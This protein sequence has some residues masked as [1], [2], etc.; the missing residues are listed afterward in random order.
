[1]IYI[2]GNDSPAVRKAALES[3]CAAFLTK[4]FATHELMESLKAAIGR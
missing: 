3:G 2:T 4:P 1:V